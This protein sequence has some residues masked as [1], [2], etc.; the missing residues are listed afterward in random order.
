MFEID[1]YD[2]FEILKK[3]DKHKFYQ[4]EGDIYKIIN[5][6]K[7][8]SIDKYITYNCVL[9]VY[10]SES[11]K[12]AETEKIAGEINQY[13]LINELIFN[14]EHTKNLSDNNIKLELYLFY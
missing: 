8:I 10:I 7:K 12:L 4:F 2:L 6:I 11:L 5:E 3:T 13:I 1:A 14:A 9:K